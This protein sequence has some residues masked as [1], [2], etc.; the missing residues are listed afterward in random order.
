[1]ITLPL[2]TA[3]RENVGQL[4]L[5]AM[6]PMRNLRWMHSIGTGS[7]IDGFEPF[8][9]FERHTGFELSAILFPLCRHL[10][11]P[12]LQLLLTQHSSLITWPVCGVHY[13]DGRSAT[14]GGFGKALGTAAVDGLDEGRPGKRILPLTDGMRMGQ[15]IGTLEVRTTTGQPRLEMAEETHGQLS[16]ALGIERLRICRY[17]PRRNPILNEAN[18]VVATKYGVQ[19][20]AYSYAYAAASDSG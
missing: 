6:L 14:A 19:L 18:K 13:R 12:P 20:S 11:S 1:M 7:L 16:C 10:P 17:D 8:E 3:Y 4:L 9:R 2:V 15:N 5:E